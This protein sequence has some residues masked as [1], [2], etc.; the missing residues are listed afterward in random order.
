VAKFH[1]WLFKRL[2]TVLFIDFLRLFYPRLLRYLD[3][4]SIEFLDKEV[5][6]DAPSG[7]S[8]EVDLVVRAKLKGHKACFLIHIEHQST[9]QA[10][11][12]LR[13]FRY[14]IRLFEKYGLPVYPIALCSFHRPKR[15]EPRTFA[16]DVAGLKVLRFNYRMIQL[17]RLDWRKF[18]RIE[19]PAAVALMAAMPIA[20][21]DRPRVKLECLR[22]L[23]RLQLDR[24]KMRV[25]REFMDAY[26]K[27]TAE[28]YVML[29]RKVEV[30]QPEEREQ[31]TE[32]LND[33][34]EEGRQ[35]GRQEGQVQ[36][37]LRLLR[38]RVGPVPTKLQDGVRALPP[39][40]LEELA[41]ALLDFSS[42]KDAR[43][44]LVGQGQAAR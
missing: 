16:L 26:L 20:E 34:V 36:L 43:N 41:E 35:E 13:M 12:R 44:W 38:R 18:M 5:L 9:S 6:A 40:R 8:R 31:V 7:H 32:V 24:E 21:K 37:V 3:I 30:L 1:D 4:S 22:M 19:N 39:E 27:M 28:E 23:A 29:K 14:F 42:L 11:F 17:G 33:W 10:Q 2:L 15:P 25:I